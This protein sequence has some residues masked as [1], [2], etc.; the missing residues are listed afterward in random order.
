MNEITKESDFLNHLQNSVKDFQKTEEKANSIA[1]SIENKEIETLPK[2]VLA[3]P[4]HKN[5]SKF[6]KKLGYNSLIYNEAKK[7]GVDPSLVKAIIKAESNFN[8]KAESPK[9]AMGLMQLMPG[10]AKD[11]GVKHPFNPAENIKGGTS[12]L[13]ELSRIFKKK[14]HVIAAY[15]AGPGA[16]KK[17]GGVPPYSETKNYVKKVKEYFSEYNK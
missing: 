9:G 2:K 16:V 1:P 15:N 4:K 12:Y 10:T 3:S 17:Y 5:T 13:K 7:N 14:D 11:L 6:P 8:P